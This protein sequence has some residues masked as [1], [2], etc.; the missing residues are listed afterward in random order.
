MAVYIVGPESGGGPFKIGYATNVDKRLCQLQTG[1]P[2]PLKVVNV[3]PGSR[4]TEK[5][6]HWVF[7]GK[8]SHGE[9]F[10]LSGR[11][12]ILLMELIEDGLLIKGK[13]EELVK[14]VVEY[15]NE[16]LQSTDPE[17][18]LDA[19]AIAINMRPETL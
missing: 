3:L 2:V 18:I 11:E 8:R 5:F 15:V 1:S 9:W 13:E 12:M 10:N 4:E 16:Q 17:V 7:R 19:A 6:L 14:V